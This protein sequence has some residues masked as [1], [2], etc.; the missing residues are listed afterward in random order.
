MILKIDEDKLVN[1]IL[2]HRPDDGSWTK[3]CVWYIGVAFIAHILGDKELLG[4][5]FNKK[6]YIRCIFKMFR[7]VFN[8]YRINR[9]KGTGF[10]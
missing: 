2:K 9:V 5:T 10:D 4:T 8:I 6:Y 7:V 1:T 3:Y